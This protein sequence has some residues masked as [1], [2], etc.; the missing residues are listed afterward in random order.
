MDISR[1]I[2][3]RKSAPPQS[4]SR[5]RHTG[6][7]FSGIT[8]QP[9]SVLSPI[10]H[11]FGRQRHQLGSSLFSTCIDKL[12]QQPPSNGSELPPYIKM[13]P[14]QDTMFRSA[15]MSMVQLYISNEIGREVVT[16][17]GELGLLQFRD[18]R[19]Q[20]PPWILL[21]STRTSKLTSRNS[22]SSMEMSA[23]SSAP[24]L[25][26]FEDSTMS[27]ASCVRHHFPTAHHETLGLG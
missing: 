7:L 12:D 15:N 2:F 19:R 21:R 6:R 18:V 3:A 13:A 20:P 26:R 23:L 17:L 8:N 14:A 22:F 25:R 27:N 1:K 10:V 11:S 5:S 24:L 4:T 16:A 9:R